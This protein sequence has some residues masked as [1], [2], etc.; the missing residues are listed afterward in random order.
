MPVIGVL[1][2]RLDNRWLIARGFGVYAC[3]AM[4]MA[5]LTLQVSEWSLVWPIILSGVASGLVFVSLSTTAMGTLS[6]EQIGNASGL[7]NLLRNVCGSVGI[8]LV[9]TIIARPEQTH[10]S[11][12][13]HDIS[14]GPAL[15][16]TVSDYRA[17]MT[18]QYC[19][20]C[21]AAPGLPDGPQHA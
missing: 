4:W 11:N 17:V 7:Y 14:H 10:R 1:I 13:A 6:N 19:A 9:N 20:E 12:L 5:N 15:Q 18:V 16:H 8:S 2:G 21:G 3:T